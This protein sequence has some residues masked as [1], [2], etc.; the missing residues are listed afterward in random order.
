M[1]RITKMIDGSWCVE[2]G[3]QDGTERWSENN[4]KEAVQSLIRGARTLNHAYI[5]E[6]DITFSEEK[7]SESQH[8][9]HVSAA[10]LE[11]LQKIR[12]GHKVV[13]DYNDKRLEYRITDVE[14]ELIVAIREGKKHVIDWVA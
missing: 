13:L 7:S 3:I 10:D 2:C 1:Y 6:D 9:E 11:L 12:Y 5:R 14:C 4:R 8:T